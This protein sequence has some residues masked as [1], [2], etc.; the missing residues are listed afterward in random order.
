MP[1]DQ[2]VYQPGGITKGLLLHCTTMCHTV[3]LAF[4]DLCCYNL[5]VYTAS[6]PLR[7]S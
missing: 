2:L 1:P 5:Q 6:K 4:D 7:W 3:L